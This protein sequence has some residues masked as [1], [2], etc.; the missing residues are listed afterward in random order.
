MTTFKFR[1]EF[2]ARQG[3]NTESNLTTVLETNAHSLV[4]AANSRT[5]VKFCSL[6]Q[7]RWWNQLKEHKEGQPDMWTSFKPSKLA[8]SV[9]PQAGASVCVEKW[10][11]HVPSVPSVNDTY[12]PK[13]KRGSNKALLTKYISTIR[14]AGI[15]HSTP[16]SHRNPLLNRPN[17]QVG[18]V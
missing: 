1:D 18:R 12:D 8:R 17:P 6:R 14:N 4:M 7:F 13:T 15:L 3:I 2:R 16:V 11:G 10:W 5:G 9:V